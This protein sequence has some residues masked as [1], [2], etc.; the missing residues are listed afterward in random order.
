MWEVAEQNRE[1][2]FTPEAATV[3]TSI[4]KRGE[5][6]GDHFIRLFSRKELCEE[7]EATDTGQRE[8]LISSKSL[9]RW[10]H[11][12]GEGGKLC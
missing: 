3:S 12:G 7:K 8:D 11:M 10:G 4:V 1:A 9:W 6:G 2:M 5:R